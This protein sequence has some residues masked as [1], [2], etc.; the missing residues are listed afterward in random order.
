MTEKLIA[1]YTNACICQDYDIETGEWS[2]ASEH[3]SDCWEQQLDDFAYIVQD[4]LDHS[5]TFKIEGF[6]TWYGTTAGIF[7]AK[8]AEEL[9]LAITPRNTEWRLQVTGNLYHLTSI[10]SHH[11]GTGTITVTPIID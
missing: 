10:L 7:D 9:L 3:I 5:H 6:P 11:D 1:E 4:I 8:N 2:E